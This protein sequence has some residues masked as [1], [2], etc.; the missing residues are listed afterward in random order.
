M[1][2]HYRIY[3]ALL[4]RHLYLGVAKPV[5]LINI[6]T[7]LGLGAALGWWWL[8]VAGSAHIVMMFIFYK[9]PWLWET[10]RAYSREG[11]VYLPRPA[12]K[13]RQ[14]PRRF[15]RSHELC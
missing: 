2:R 6:V 1:R 11:D 14:W 13:L 8:I 12:R 15:D 3:R 4:E 9:D 7:G 5:Y 10:Y